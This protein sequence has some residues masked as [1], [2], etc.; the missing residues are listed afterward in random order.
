MW[1]RGTFSIKLP[2]QKKLAFQN[3]KQTETENTQKIVT[4]FGEKQIR[5]KQK[6]FGKTS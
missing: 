1:K 3:V 6:N 4:N 5:T 2:V